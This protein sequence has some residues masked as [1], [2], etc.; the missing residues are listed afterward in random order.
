MRH[1]PS[2]SL[3]AACALAAA[4][5]VAGETAPKGR[6]FESST[7]SKEA[8]A[9]LTELQLRVENFQQGPANQELAKKIVAADPTWALGQYYL[10]VFQVSPADA[11]REYQKARE[12]A[13]NASD[14]ERRFIEALQHV[15]LNQGVDFKKSIPPLEAVARDYPGERL[16]HVILGQLYNGA[17]EGA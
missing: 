6:A 7:K 3:A 4:V 14:G 17:A 15:R 11:E 10:S 9:L 1:I 16:V 8:R 2:V 5:S 13:K 12:L